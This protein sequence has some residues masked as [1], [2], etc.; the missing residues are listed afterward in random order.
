MSGEPR[1]PQACGAC[2]PGEKNSS[3]SGGNYSDYYRSLPRKN[4]TKARSGFGR[5]KQ[6]A[7]VSYLLVQKQKASK[8]AERE[9]LGGLFCFSPPSGKINKN[10]GNCC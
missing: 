1:M 3:K 9:D 4:L 5:W 8:S 10:Y 6:I 7:G 2:L